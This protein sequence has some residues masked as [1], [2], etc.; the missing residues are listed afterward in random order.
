[1]AYHWRDDTNGVHLEAYREERDAVLGTLFGAEGEETDGFTAEVVFSNIL[2]SYE[3]ITTDN[4]NF[5]GVFVG[6]SEETTLSVGWA[7]GQGL[8]VVASLNEEEDFDAG[9]TL[10]RESTLT[11]VALAWLF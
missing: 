10:T 2:I 5:N 1:M 7:P 3:S 4:T 11:A 6:E 8:A 9:G